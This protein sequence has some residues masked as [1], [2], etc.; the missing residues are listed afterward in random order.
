MFTPT[1]WA[2]IGAALTTYH[3]CRFL[4]W[5]DTPKRR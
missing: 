5:V 2:V 4:I 1:T 3:L